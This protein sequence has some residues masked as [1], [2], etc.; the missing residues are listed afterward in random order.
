M[1]RDFYNKGFNPYYIPRIIPG[2][3]KYTIHYWLELMEKHKAL[4]YV[5]D[6]DPNTYTVN[7]IAKG[8]I[9][10]ARL[11]NG[12]FHLRT[13]NGNAVAREQLIQIC[14]FFT[15]TGLTACQAR[16]YSA[17]QLN[18]FATALT[19]TMSGCARLQRAVGWC[20]TAASHSQSPLR[21]GVL[22]HRVPSLQCESKA[23]RFA[24]VIALQV[25]PV[26]FPS[27]DDGLGS[28]KGGTA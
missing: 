20:E 26:A 5:S 12:R 23:V 15:F 18:R 24:P 16:V 8:Q 19:R 1:G 7:A 27:G 11:K 14:K 4:K 17:P 28:N 6:G 13:Y 21:A 25:R 10:V 2:A 9:N 3:G 22:N